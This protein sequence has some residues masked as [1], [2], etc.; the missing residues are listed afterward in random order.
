MNKARDWFQ[1]AIKIDP[2]LGDTWAHFYKFELQHGTEVRIYM[3]PAFS[4][5]HIASSPPPSPPPPSPS[6]QAQQEQVLK[7][8]V[9][10]EPRHGEMWCA[11][12]KDIK[13]WQKHT[14]QVLPLVTATIHIKLG[15]TS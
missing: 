9:L 13:N 8:C 6:S 14:A 11:V 12:S 4:V 10:A 7:N 5:D 15:P 1:R 3:E 2:D